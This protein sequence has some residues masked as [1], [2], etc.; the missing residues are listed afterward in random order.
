[1]WAYFFGFPQKG[2]WTISHTLERLIKTDAVD[3]LWLFG[4]AFRINE[5]SPGHIKAICK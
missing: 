1:V 4:F 5:I 2:E 3:R